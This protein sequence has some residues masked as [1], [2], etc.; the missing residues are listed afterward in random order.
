M[1]SRMRA[2]QWK[3]EPQGELLCLMAVAVWSRVLAGVLILETEPARWLPSL[4]LRRGPLG[5]A[6]NGC[7]LVQQLLLSVLASRQL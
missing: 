2:S 3:Q 5:D 4:L 7:A 6:D 1:A